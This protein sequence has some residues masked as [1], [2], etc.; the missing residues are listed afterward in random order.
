MN[1]QFSKFLGIFRTQVNEKFTF[2]KSDFNLN[3]IQENDTCFM[4]PTKQA[5]IK[6]LLTKGH[7]LDMNII[8]KPTYSEEIYG[9]K[10]LCGYF[11]ISHKI[12]DGF[13]SPAQL[14]KLISDYSDLFKNSI[15]TLL[16]SNKIDWSK[17]DAYAKNKSIIRERNEADKES[18]RKA[19][20]IKNEA[21]VA[22]KEKD[23]KRVV[24]LL[25]SIRDSLTVAEN[26]KFHYALKQLARKKT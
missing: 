7:N 2:V 10:L 1:D 24:K 13:N 15:L 16:I 25:N 18:K 12:R 6:I 17:I 26:K 9:I 11:N 22:F 19:D 21:E 4:V 5:D 20:K 14:I 8:L 3:L 23:F